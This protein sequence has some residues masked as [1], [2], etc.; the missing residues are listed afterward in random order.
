MAVPLRFAPHTSL[1]LL[2]D[3]TAHHCF[4]TSSNNNMIR[5]II[6]SNQGNALPAEDVATPTPRSAITAALSPSKDRIVLFYQCLQNGAGNKNLGNVELYF[7]TFIK[8]TAANT[9]AWTRTN[10]TKL[11]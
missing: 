7:M 10:A 5:K 8:P 9:T 3:G 2:D 1:A 11:G 4:Y 6:I